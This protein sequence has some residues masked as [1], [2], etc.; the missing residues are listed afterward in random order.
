MAME[1]TKSEIRLTMAR[2]TISSLT[3]W[4]TSSGNATKSGEA[5]AAAS[6][7]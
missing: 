3:Q 4:L 1:I 2:M 5:V 6:H 7:S